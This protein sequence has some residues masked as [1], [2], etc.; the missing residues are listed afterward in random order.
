MRALGNWALSVRNRMLFWWQNSVFLF[1]YELWLAKNA[2]EIVAQ[3]RDDPERTLKTLSTEVDRV[4]T[5]YRQILKIQIPLQVYLVLYLFDTELPV[6][7]SGI[8][9][10]KLGLFND[11]IYFISLMIGL[12]SLIDS[13]RGSC[14]RGV[15]SFY[16]TVMANPRKRFGVKIKNE[17]IT[18]FFVNYIARG[19][20]NTLYLSRVYGYLM[21]S[22]SLLFVLILITTMVLAIV[23]Y[24]SVADKLLV[25]ANFGH[26]WSEVIYFLSISIILFSILLFF[27]HG[28]P[29]P[30]SNFTAIRALIWAR[31]NDAM[32]RQRLTFRSG[33]CRRALFFQML[34]LDVTDPPDKYERICKLLMKQYNGPK[35]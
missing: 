15:I 2:N 12:A 17:N 8:N 22:I 19:H 31:K 20:G 13:V 21:I 16:E 3:L 9:L 18:D 5:R 24:F 11:I 23:V 1:G 4:R 28:L 6:S 32:L 33:P 35:E 7:L 34:Y 29:I 30:Y 27:A 14:F 10:E 26:K 25:Q